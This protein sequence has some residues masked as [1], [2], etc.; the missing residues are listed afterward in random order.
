MKYYNRSLDEV[1]GKK[2]LRRIRSPLLTTIRKGKLEE[3]AI[4]LLDERAPFHS[5]YINSYLPI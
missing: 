4:V 2:E 3:L 1:V 5:G